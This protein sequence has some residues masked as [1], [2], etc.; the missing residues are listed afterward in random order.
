MSQ[1]GKRNKALFPLAVSRRMPQSQF[2]V[3]VRRDNFAR[4]AHVQEYEGKGQGYDRR[5]T[6]TPVAV[7]DLQIPGA[8]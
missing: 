1:Q 8:R 5:Y 7:R 4:R 2:S 3:A 6:N